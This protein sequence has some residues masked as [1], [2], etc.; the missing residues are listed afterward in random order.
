L[1]IGNK[2]DLIQDSSA[3]YEIPVKRAAFQDCE[4]RF[5]FREVCQDLEDEKIS[6]EIFAIQPYPCFAVVI[7]RPAQAAHIEVDFHGGPVFLFSSL[8]Q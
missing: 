7:K 8:F 3:G 4:N 2:P 5:C 1:G 6:S